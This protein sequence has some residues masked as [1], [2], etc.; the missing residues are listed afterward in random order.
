MQYSSTVK[1][2]GTEQVDSNQLDLSYTAPAFRAEDGL[3]SG[4][5]NFLAAAPYTGTGFGTCALLTSVNPSGNKFY[6]Q[7]TTYAPKAV[8]DITLNNVATQVFRFGVISRSLFVK[9][10]GSFSYTAVVIQVPDD[11]PGYAFGVF[12]N[13][14]ICPGSSTC[15]TTG[16]LKLRA[17]VAIIDSTPDARRPTPDAPIAGQRQ[18][19][20]ESW[21]DQ[22]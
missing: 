1:H 15:N 19:D 9:E 8:L 13:A 21:S 14:Y 17:K 5:A 7:G 2:T 3:I 4:A 16:P 11:S 18:I 12:L 6:V 10:T 22:R 20:I